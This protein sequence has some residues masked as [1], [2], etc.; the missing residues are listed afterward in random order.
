MA[1]GLPFILAIKIVWIFIR[2]QVGTVSNDDLPVD[3]VEAYNK[4]KDFHSNKSSSIL[5]DFVK[6]H[7]GWDEI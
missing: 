3:L 2:Y 1:M 7:L 5:T 4:C 6:K